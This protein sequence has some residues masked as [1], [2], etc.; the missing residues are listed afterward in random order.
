MVEETCP[1]VGARAFCCQNP[2]MPWSRAE[3]RAFCMCCR[4]AQNQRSATIAKVHF[5]LWAHKISKSPK[6]SYTERAVY[7]PG[8]KMAHSGSRPCRPWSCML[9]PSR[10][11]TCTSWRRATI[12]SLPQPEIIRRFN[13]SILFCTGCL[14]SFYLRRSHAGQWVIIV[15][16]TSSWWEF[17]EARETW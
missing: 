4:P 9:S 16:A 3:L 10:C 13:L 5:G 2:G 15:L 12:S 11:S 17:L 8:R 14:T 1:C 6:K 7:L